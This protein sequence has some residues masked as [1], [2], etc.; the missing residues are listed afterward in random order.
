MSKIISTGYY[1]P[2]TVVSTQ[3]MLDEAR[4]ARFGVG[5]DYIERSLGV[6]KVRHSNDMP[7]TL[8]VK[9]A[10]KALAAADINP[11]DIG[12]IIFTG[13]EGD[14]CE[15]ATAHFVQDRLGLKSEICFD[16]SNACLGFMSGLKVANDMIRAGTS[17]YALICTGERPS[18]VSKSV[19][20]S[21]RLAED[22]SA[23]KKSVGMLSV[24]DAGGAVIIGSNKD[25][26]RG[27]HRFSTDSQGKHAKLCH[28]R[29]SD[30][31]VDGQMIMGK[32]CSLTI[33]LHR[34]VYKK[35]LDM[36]GWDAGSIDCLITH[37]VGERPFHILSQAFAV[38]TDKMTKT[39]NWL[40]NLTSATFPVNLGLA[41][42]S[43]QVKPG[44]RVYASMSGS[45]ITV[46]HTGFVA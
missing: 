13:I 22:E 3:D 4:A 18:L 23:F 2:G 32:I 8:A 28:Y 10:E 24:G 42:E 11:D 5:A 17:K 30:N 6:Q 40:G 43:G 45:G 21:L 12:I 36:L 27:F 35:T 25:Q 31:K 44:D 33:G 9:A 19:V 39:Y 38:A 37:Q 7:S 34:V 29:W 46:C 41:L 14:Y 26:N 1:L 20:D 16:V 15:P